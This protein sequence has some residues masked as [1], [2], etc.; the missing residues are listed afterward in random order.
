M[1]FS[2]RISRAGMEDSGGALA[3]ERAS[4]E[5]RIASLQQAPSTA[6]ARSMNSG[7]TQL[8]ALRS[9]GSVT[10]E[11]LRERASMRSGRTRRYSGARTHGYACGVCTEVKL[12]RPRNNQPFFLQLAT[13][14]APSSWICNTCFEVDLAVRSLLAPCPRRATDS[15][16]HSHRASSS[17]PPSP[18]P[19]SCHFF[20][21]SRTSLRSSCSCGHST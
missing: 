21:I 12:G 11:K 4:S 3:A 14:M 17:P 19:A 9:E 5:S 15:H 16:A 18:G 7:A 20:R 13:P 8:R 6:R 1:E 10:L 2:D